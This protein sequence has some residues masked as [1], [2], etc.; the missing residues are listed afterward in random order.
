MSLRNCQ[1]LLC[2]RG[3]EPFLTMSIQVTAWRWYRKAKGSN[4]LPYV[5]PGLP[6]T[7]NQDWMAI[8]AV[9]T[10]QMRNTYYLPLFIA[11]TEKMHCTQ[12]A[13]HWRKRN[14][15]PRHSEEAR[16]KNTQTEEEDLKKISKPADRRAIHVSQQ[17]SQPG[18]CGALT[19]A[20]SE[21]LW[22]IWLL[23]HHFCIT[24]ALEHHISGPC[25]SNLVLN[26]FCFL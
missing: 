8:P 13:T 22:S 17:V 20:V 15:M 11:W 9:W 21:I 3:K 19:K 1:G 14:Y 24:S 7:T 6:F 23:E 4:V 12:W 16:K 26:F 18:D 2:G 10:K 5:I 25:A